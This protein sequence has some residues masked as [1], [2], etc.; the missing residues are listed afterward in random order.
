[1]RPRPT[2]PTA[3]PT[4]AGVFEGALIIIVVVWEVVP[5]LLPVAIEEDD[6]EVG[7]GIRVLGSGRREDSTPLTL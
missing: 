5:S 7:V 2:A 4:I 1:M 6:D 3:P